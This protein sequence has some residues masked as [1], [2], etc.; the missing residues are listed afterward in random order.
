MV[1]GRWTSA[2]GGGCH[3]LGCVWVRKLKSVTEPG[4]KAGSSV[5]LDDTST[6]GL[7]TLDTMFTRP[8][9]AL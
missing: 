9:Q 6:E 2:H 4:T 5:A 3:P 7:A 8:A 1:L